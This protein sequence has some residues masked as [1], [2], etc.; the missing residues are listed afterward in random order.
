MKPMIAIVATSGEDRNKS[1]L[2]AIV[3][4]GGKPILLHS[5][6]YFEKKSI[7]GILLTG[8]GDLSECSYDHL[9]SEVEQKTLGKI[10]PEREKYEDQLLGWA[11]KNNIPV[12]GI[13]RGC[14]IMNVFARGTLIPDIP[15]WQKE[16]GV[17]P[18]LSH[19]ADKDVAA[20]VH[21]ISIDSNSQLYKIFGGQKILGVNSSHHQALSRCGH[22]LTVT[23]RAPDGII[24]GIEDP[25]KIFWIGV[26]FHPERMWKD[27]PVFSNLF[28]HFT[29]HAQQKA[30]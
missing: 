8:G 21:D 9:L 3:A 22:S 19:R 7:C 2:D 16:N 20:P 15:L 12:L 30:Q 10:E 25:S 14:Q 11:S 28:R 4:H 26:Q 5:G 17:S 18:I 27:F 23:A 13:C 29:E 6:D 24:E 1:Y